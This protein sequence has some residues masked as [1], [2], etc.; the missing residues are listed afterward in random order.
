MNLRKSPVLI[1]FQD[2]AVASVQAA[3]VPQAGNRRFMVS[4]GPMLSGAAIAQVLV[5][6]FPELVGRVRFDTPPS[7]RQSTG[8][9]PV[10][11]ADTQLTST[12]LGLRQYRRVEDTL[13][14]IAEQIVDLQRRQNWR[15]IIQS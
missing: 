4:A 14:G 11:L 10:G 5:G 13:V 2:F 8:L 1:K 6:R 12:I 3:F 15:R 9:S 7:R